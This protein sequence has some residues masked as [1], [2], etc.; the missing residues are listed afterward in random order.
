M[1][2]I[3]EAIQGR[4]AAEQT[5]REMAKPSAMIWP[6][7]LSDYRRTWLDARRYRN[8]NYADRYIGKAY[9]MWSIVSGDSIEARFLL[10]PYRDVIEVFENLPKPHGGD[11]HVSIMKAEIREEVWAHY[12]ANPDYYEPEYTGDST[13]LSEEVIA[14]NLRFLDTL[15]KHGHLNSWTADKLKSRIK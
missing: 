14:S 2:N 10:G 15:V 1:A 6:E 4:W 11:A 5:M 3:E 9:E 12:K 13:K 7:V 8:G